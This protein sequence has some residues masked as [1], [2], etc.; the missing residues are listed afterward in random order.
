MR[1]LSGRYGP[2]VKH[3]SVNANL[4]RGADPQT[5]TLERAVTLLAEREAKGGGKKPARKPGAAPGR[6]EQMYGCTGVDSPENGVKCTGH[7]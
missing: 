3:E 5:L 4:A 6:E 7:P 1:L 2:Y